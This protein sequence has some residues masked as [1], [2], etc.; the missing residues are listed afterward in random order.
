MLLFSNFQPNINFVQNS[1]IQFDS[2][3]EQSCYDLDNAIIEYQ[4]ITNENS[5]KNENTNQSSSTALKPK[6]N[7]CDNKIIID[8]TDNNK[9]GKSLNKR[10]RKRKN[11]IRNA[12]NTK[13]RKDNEMKKIK[14]YLIN[15]I[16]D[17][18]KNFLLIINI[19][20]VLKEK[21]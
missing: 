17:N 14:A 16:F 15:F 3:D 9:N 12:K 13:F 11:E 7:E 4:D 19:V 20:K 18:L 10:G 5:R 21:I 2:L 6:S 1:I 8:I